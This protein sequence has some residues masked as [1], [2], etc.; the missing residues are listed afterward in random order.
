[1]LESAVERKTVE[2]PPREALRAIE[3]TTSPEGEIS[4]WLPTRGDPEL[5]WSWSTSPRGRYVKV[6]GEARA[7]PRKGQRNAP[8]SLRPPMD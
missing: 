2:P 5:R 1:M 4:I 6:G 3:P 7:E 8:A